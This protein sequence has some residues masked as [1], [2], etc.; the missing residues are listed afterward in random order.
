[1]RVIFDPILGRLR[2]KDSG[3]GQSP[4]THIVAASGGDYTTLTAALTAASAGDTIYIMPGSYSE[5]GGTFSLANLTIVGAGD[6]TTV[7][8]LSGGLTL[9]GNYLKLR[10]VT[11]D[12]GSSLELLLSGQ[13]DELYGN[14]IKGSN[15]TY[16]ASS[17]SYCGFSHNFFEATGGSA[18]CLFTGARQTIDGNHFTAPH[19][20]NGGIYVN[21]NS[22]FTANDIHEQQIN[23]G[24]PPLLS[25]Q[26]FAV[27]SGNSFFGG[28]GACVSMT[29]N[30]AFVGNML[31]QMGG[32]VITA[33]EYC[34]VSGNLIQINNGLSSDVGIY[35]NPASGKGSTTVNGNSIFSNNAGLGTG[36]S[37]NAGADSILTGNAIIACKTGVTIATGVTNTVV[38]ANSFVGYTTTISDS[39]TGTINANNAS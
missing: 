34:T 29:P 10:G 16:F 33:P 35:I 22:T 2:T 21:Q 1:M 14:H 38:V 13:R 26:D 12:C 31:Y 4:Y 32:N 11:I 37:V 17:A 24:G 36:I 20:T 30:A 23:G 3:G 19:T 18:R 28:N 25:L 39:G 5:A 8:T 9:S 15:T 6:E 27:A 7:L